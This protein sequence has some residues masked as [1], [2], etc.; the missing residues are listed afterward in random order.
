[1]IGAGNI[2]YVQPIQ[3]EQQNKRLR[4]IYIASM[5][6]LKVALGRITCVASASSGI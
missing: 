4:S 2:R 6:A 3:E 1:M 5:M